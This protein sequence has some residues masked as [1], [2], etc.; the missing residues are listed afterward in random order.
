ME[1]IVYYIGTDRLTANGSG[2]CFRVS[3]NNTWGYLLPGR[4]KTPSAF[5]LIADTAQDNFRGNGGSSYFY[6]D[7]K[8]SQSLHLVH[9]GRTAAGF[10]DGH[11]T[12]LSGPELQTKT[13]NQPVAWRLPDGTQKT[14]E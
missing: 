6:S 3:R 12:T 11:V 14:N 4:C 7:K 1:R 10:V 5:L 13:V 8:H 9:E 2:E